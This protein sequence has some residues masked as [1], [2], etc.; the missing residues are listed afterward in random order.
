MNKHLGYRMLELVLVRVLPEL[1]E[2][3]VKELM[4]MRLGAQDV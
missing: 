3:T 4:E 2:K 1:G